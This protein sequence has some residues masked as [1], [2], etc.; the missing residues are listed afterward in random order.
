MIR[1]DS[2]LGLIT[3]IYLV[4]MDKISRWVSK[5]QR[6]KGDVRIPSP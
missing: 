1:F 3:F 2:S 6:G 5:A 4:T